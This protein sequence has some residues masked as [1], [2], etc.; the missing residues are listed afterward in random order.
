MFFVCWQILFVETDE[1]GQRQSSHMI[2]TVHVYQ[3]RVERNH[4]RGPGGRLNSVLRGHTSNVFLQVICLLSYL[5]EFVCSWFCLLY[6][7]LSR[8]F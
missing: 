6:D 2:F 1:S 8:N 7:S 3:Y 4:R 5:S